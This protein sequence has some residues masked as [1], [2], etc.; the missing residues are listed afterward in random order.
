MDTD[1]PAKRF[2]YGWVILVISFIM[3]GCALGF[4]S[5]TNGGT[6]LHT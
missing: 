6:A 2:H 5:G 4:C 1:K 3:V